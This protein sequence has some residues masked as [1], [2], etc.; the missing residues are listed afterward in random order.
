MQSS[1]KLVT[2][3]FMLSPNNTSW[4]HERT[5]LL[6]IIIFARLEVKSFMSERTISLHTEAFRRLPNG[7]LR[8]KTVGRRRRSPGYTP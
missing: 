2:M 4:M 6:S 3:A 1:F 5:L 7:L 8:E